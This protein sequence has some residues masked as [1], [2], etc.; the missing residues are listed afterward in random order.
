LY[1]AQAGDANNAGSIIEFRNS[2]SQNPTYRTIIDGLPTAG[3]E[4]E[5][6][7]VDGISVLGRGTNQGIYAIFGLSPQATGSNNFGAL[8]KINLDGT[9]NTL[10]NVGS[11]DYIGRVCL[12]INLVPR[13]T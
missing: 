8:L 13:G 5:F 11:F 4:G 1:V 3:D 9:T 2:M 7:G 6:L 10:A 12:R